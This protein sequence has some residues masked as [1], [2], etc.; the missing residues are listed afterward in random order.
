[1]KKFGL[2]GEKLGHSFSKPIHEKIAGYTYEI[3]EI[4]KE[5]LDAFM[6][7]KDFWDDIGKEMGEHGR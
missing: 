4:P 2:I 5:D 6:K 1:M 3:K 7:A